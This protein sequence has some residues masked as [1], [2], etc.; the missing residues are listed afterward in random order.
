MGGISHETECWSLRSLLNLPLRQEL[1]Q[2]QAATVATNAQDLCLCISAI[3]SA[4]QCNQIGS[5]SQKG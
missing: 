2:R 4:H 5:E 1:A 3:A